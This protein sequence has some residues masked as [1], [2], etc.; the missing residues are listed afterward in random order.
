M[1]RGVSRD[2]L[3]AHDERQN[4]LI[5]SL[6]EG[7]SQMVVDDPL[8]TGW[9]GLMTVDSVSD[10]VNAAGYDRV[11]VQSADDAALTGVSGI[12]ED[13]A[14]AIIAWRGKNR[15]NSIA[16]LLDVVAAPA[17]NQTGQTGQPANANPAQA[18][19]QDNSQAGGQPSGPKVFSDTLLMDIAD[20]LTTQSDSELQGLVNINTA[21]LEVLACLPGLD[22]QLAQAIISFRQSNGFFSNVAGLL[23]VP[24]VTVDIFKQ[25]CPRVTAR[26]ETFRILCEGKVNATGARHRIQEIVHIGL[27]SVTTLSYREDDL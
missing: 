2:L 21:T 9:A 8:D 22:R 10:N 4:G 26:S 25:V 16:D 6:D 11:N 3:L 12:T 15:I 18:Q 20:D 14:K 27:R 1:V 19:G 24:G 17:D 7:G 13:I 23:R 5:D